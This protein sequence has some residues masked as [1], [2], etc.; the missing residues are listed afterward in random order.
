VKI[1]KHDFVLI[2]SV[3]RFQGESKEYFLLRKLIYIYSTDVLLIKIIEKKTKNNFLKFHDDE[4]EYVVVVLIERKSCL[5]FLLLDMAEDIVN[6]DKPNE[7]ECIENE[8]DG[9][10]TASYRKCHGQFCL[11]PTNNQFEYEIPLD[12]SPFLDSL[13]KYPSTSYDRIESLLKLDHS[14]DRVKV[15]IQNKHITCVDLCLYYLQRVQKA[16]NYYKT[17]IELNPHLLSDAKQLDEQINENETTNKLLFGCVAAI[18]GNISVRNMFNDAGAYVLH[19]KKM[20]EDAPIVKKLRDE[21]T[22]ILV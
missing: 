18:K 1:R 19:D 12:F 13:T 8:S 4:N 5:S 10:E 20:K 21:G 2:F 17:I 15:L 16:N 11:T 9:L 22:N 3:F 6:T 14:I 7:T